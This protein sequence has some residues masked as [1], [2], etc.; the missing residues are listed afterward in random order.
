MNW[1]SFFKKLFLLLVFFYIEIAISF[2]DKISFEKDFLL[3][4]NKAISTRLS[5]NLSRYVA[6]QE[7]DTYIEEFVKK[8]DITGAS[9]A[10]VKNGRLIYAKGFGYAD[11]EN[12][13]KVQPKHIFRLA[14]V[15]K[16]ITATTIMKMVE[17]NKIS[18]S[19]TV[20]GKSGILNDSLFLDIRDKR[21]KDIT[22]QTLLDHS[23]GFTKRYG[24]PMFKYHSISRKLKK[25]LPLAQ[26][27]II[28]YALKYRRLGFVPGK[29]KSYSNL[30]YV[31]LGQVIEKVSQTNYEDYVVAN[32]LNPIGIYD[33]HIGKSEK[34]DKFDNEVVYNG[35]KGENNVFSSFSSKEIVPKYYGGNSI[36]ALGSA[37]GWVASPAELMKFIVAIDGNDYPKDLLNEKSIRK[38]AYPGKGNGPYGWTGTNANGDWWRTGTLSGTSALVKRQ[39]DGI[40]W[41]FLINS[42]AKTGARF[43]VQINKTM[44]RAISTIKKWP[45]Y[46]L[47]DYYEPKSLDSKYFAVKD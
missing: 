36:E 29:R 19:D 30:G 5:N 17:Q 22:I 23:A 8:W 10:L 27:D 9:V 24:D 14:S 18:L 33:M 37:G 26:D 39:S 40:S 25:E 41:V 1:R 34:K 28:H 38:M 31:I 13:I 4:E 46:N 35:L 2:S 16:L 47:F 15:S 20:F 7:F 6:M 44:I 42:T 43:P 11:R 3:N 32:I 45:D 21:V 12:K